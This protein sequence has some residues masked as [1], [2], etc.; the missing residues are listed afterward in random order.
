MA[1]DKILTTILEKYRGK[2]V[3]FDIWAT[4]CGPCRAAHKTILPLKEELKNEDVVF[5]YLTGTTSPVD[6]WSEMIKEISGEHYY[7]TNEQYQSV[8]NQYK[9]QGV[10]TYLIFDRN[11][12]FAYKSVGYPGNETMK[13]NLLK[14][15]EK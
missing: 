14:A 7:L 5:V 10:P 3:F 8:L 6:K 15:L 12:N 13:A 9:S 4:W 2:A 11:G 1:P